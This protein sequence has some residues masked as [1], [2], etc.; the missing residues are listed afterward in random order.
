MNQLRE[1]SRHL[2]SAIAAKLDGLPGSM[3]M[4]TEE[5]R[6][7]C[8]QAVTLCRG[9]REQQIDCVLTAQDL[10]Q[11]LHNLIEYSYY[12]YEED[13]ARGF[14]TIEGGHRVGVC[15]RAV[16]RDGQPVLLKEISSLNIRFAREVRGC[17]RRLLP[18]LMEGGNIH[19]TLIISPPGCGK[20]TLLRD[21]AR[22]LSENRFHVSICDERSELAGMYRSRPGFDLGPRCDVL[23]GCDKSIGIPML[24]RSMAPQVVITDE[25]GR[26]EDVAAAMQCLVSG[27]RLVT[28]IHGTGREDAERSSIGSLVK[29]GFF[30]RLVCL[31]REQGAGTVR[32]VIRID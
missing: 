25:I 6:M 11:I 10:Q 32:E 5:I 9:S 31:G 16:V 17:C 1:I 13:L 28:S 24:I 27:V 12:A 15:G 18:E 30:R 4:D 22:E 29:Q 21:I 14:V 20:T 19:N 3:T 26:P 8:G 2:P 7:R 23:D